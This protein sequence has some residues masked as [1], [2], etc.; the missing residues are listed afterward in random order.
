MTENEKTLKEVFEKLIPIYEKAVVEM[1][2]IMW[3]NYL[4]V[5]KLAFGICWA[6]D[7][8][9]GISIFV[10][11]PDSIGIKTP[12][13]CEMYEEAKQTLIDRIDYMKN[14]LQK[15]EI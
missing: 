6:S 5:N 10:I 14:E 9:L 3:L 13:Y 4:D 2:E 12:Y 7:E 11:I 1:P 8:I 15:F